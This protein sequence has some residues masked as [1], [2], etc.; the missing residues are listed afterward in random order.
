MSVDTHVT[1]VGEVCAVVAAHAEQ[2]D[3][4]AVFPAEALAA[5]RRTGL[6]GL[7]VP[8]E[9][10]GGG[11]GPSDLVDVTMA[12][13]R[14][15]LSV[16]MIFA[17]HSQQVAA[18]AGFGRGEFHA[19]L[20]RRVARGEAYLASVTTEH[21]KGGHLLSSESAVRLAKGMLH[22][23]RVAPVVTGGTVA[24]GFLITTLAPGATSPHQVDLVY[25]AR[26]QLEITVLGDWNPVGMR[27]TESVALR[28]VGSVPEDQAIGVRG[29]FRSIVTALFV[30]LAHLGW[31]AAWLGAAAG[32]LS[33]VVRHI[34]GADGR[35]QFDHTSELLLVRLAGV[36]ARLD[37]VHGLLRHTLTV[38]EA[39]G[40]LSA[41]ATQLLINALKVRAADEC[42]AAVHELVELTGMRHGYLVGSTMFLERSFRDLRSASL[43]YSN[44]RLML[45][46]GS[47]ALLDSGARLA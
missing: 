39:G 44:D 12:L 33:R 41:P 3:R 22:V 23:D 18:I 24:D 11:G 16:A 7:L 5:M 45:V 17:M 30:P 42:F 34:R 31:S 4:T 20:L 14:V 47:L 8:D 38:V 29:D 9:F 27:A 32:A 1:A 2:T 37:A 40:D 21:G 43:N 13:G 46:N 26:D 36:R 35:K 28:L 6:L 19:D 15:D 25:A 10:G